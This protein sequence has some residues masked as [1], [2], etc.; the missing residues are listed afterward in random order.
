MGTKYTP[1]KQRELMETSLRDVRKLVDQIEAEEARERQAH[2]RIFV[3][4]GAAV[5]VLVVIVGYVVT[6]APSGATVTI[7]P[8]PAK[9]R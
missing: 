2:R 5:L 8:S 4:L 9:S 3:I 7:P 6:R 1:E